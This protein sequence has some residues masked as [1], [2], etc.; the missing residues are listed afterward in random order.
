MPYPQ[1]TKDGKVAGFIEGTTFWKKVKASKH[2]LRT[3]CGWA[4]DATIFDSLES[5]GINLIRIIDTET[6]WIYEATYQT[7]KDNKKPI[8]RLGYD[9]QYVLTMPYWTTRNY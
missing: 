6:K 4:V 9:K 5:Y 7:F 8:E 2:Q 1:K 3:P